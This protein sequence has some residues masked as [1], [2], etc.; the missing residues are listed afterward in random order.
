MQVKKFLSFTIALLCFSY[1]FASCKGEESRRKSPELYEFKDSGPGVIENEFLLLELDPQTTEIVL[2]EKKTGNQW[3]SNPLNGK[4][5]DKADKY[6]QELLRSQF[7]LGYS[8]E[9][10]LEVN[11]LSSDLCVDKKQYAYSVSDGGIEVNYA[12]GN[13]PKTYIIPPALPESRIND[14]LSK[15]SSA[16][17]IKAKRNYA[18]YSIRSID[19][20]ENKD[21]ILA[22][23]P[24]IVDETYY[25]LRDN[26]QEFMKIQTEELFKNA[27]YT[28]ED[29]EDDM[30]KYNPASASN[31]Q[32]LFNITLRYEL[33]GNSLVISA[34]F[35][36]IAYREKW[37]LTSLNILP[38]FGAGGLE[39]Q[40]YYM[41]PDGSGALI[42]F[43]NGKQRQNAYFNRIYG[44]DD[45]EPRSAVIN[46][47]SA[48]YPVFGIE[49]NGSALICIIEE[50]A[51][52]AAIKAD[53]SLRNCSWNSAS[54]QFSIIKGAK[55]EVANRPDNSMYLYQAGLPEGERIAMRFAPCGQSGYVGMAKEYRS[56]LR[57]KLNS[58]GKV[59]GENPAAVVEIIG[60]VNKTQHR[61][62]LPFD[63]PLRLTSFKEAQSMVEG[64][65]SLGWKNLNIK[66]SGWFNGGVEHKVPL[67]PALVGDLGSKKDF[68]NLLKSAE[69]NNYKLYTEGDFVFMRGKGLFDGFNDYSDVSRYINQEQAANWPFSFVWFGERKSSGKLMSLATP[70]FT[71]KTLLDFAGW[72]GKFGIQNFALR[73]IGSSLGGN[74]DEKRPVSREA[75]MKI[76]EE[77][78]ADL[79][80]KGSSFIVNA[81]FAYVLPYADFITG[82]ALRDQG[83]GITDEAVPFYQIALHGIVP[84]AGKPVNL[85][86]DYR[87]NLLDTAATGAGLY[88][89]FIKAK[90]TELQE[91]NFRNYYANEYDAWINE[92]DGLYKKFDTDFKGLFGMTIENHEILAPGVTL[93]EY[94]DGT[95]VLVNAGSSRYVYD[96]TAAAPRDWAVI[97]NEAGKYGE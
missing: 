97:R 26:I 45:C 43:N 84:Y 8:D 57:K 31:I 71:Q 79:A 19:L 68:L 51:P 16:D 88:F 65:A 20:V 77:T 56:W 42:R 85:A 54:A 61:L 37:P 67:K 87:S 24:G 83:F 5:D 21:E 62:G 41:V 55:L 30:A 38:F 3:R 72:A 94:E 10:G 52:Y 81:G 29:Y 49:K 39:D 28:L 18:I 96:G 76:Q 7:S 73:S 1:F 86:G 89:S 12:V 14:Y 44:W 23:Y 53:V 9:K 40:G 32:P 59:T 74:Y 91:T 78:L 60:A 35:E 93:T 50:G 95:K 47:Y 46:D 58:P 69:N 11:I 27:G 6:T 48:A 34:P 82:M 13:V 80:S 36:K 2:T 63:L 92:A 4:T 33:D 90:T 15:M 66:F 25:V 70:E 75:S 17:S 22:A 64:F